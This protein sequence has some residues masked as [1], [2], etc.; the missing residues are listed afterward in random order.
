VDTE[1]L[2]KIRTA[3]NNEDYQ[4]A[5]RIWGEYARELRLAIE[6]CNCTQAQ[7]DGAFELVRWTREMNLCRRSHAV[8]RIRQSRAASIYGSPLTAG[9]SLIQTSL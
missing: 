8:E 3:V 9:P 1:F 2:A 5:L 4:G 7:I 6:H